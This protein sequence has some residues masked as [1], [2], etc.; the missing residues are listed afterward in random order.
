[1]VHR[2]V[3]APAPSVDPHHPART[4]GA[5]LQKRKPGEDERRFNPHPESFG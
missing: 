2:L 4:P 3:I 1:M 5:T